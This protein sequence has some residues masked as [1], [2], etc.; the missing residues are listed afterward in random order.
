[1]TIHDSIHERQA[2]VDAIVAKYARSRERKPSMP[3]TEERVNVPMAFWDELK[4]LEDGPL[5]DAMASQASD[6]YAEGEELGDQYVFFVGRLSLSAVRI[7]L[8]E[9]LDSRDPGAFR[10]AIVNRP[11]EVYGD[12]KV[13]QI[14]RN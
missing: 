3:A 9:L 8:Q 4:W 10:A 2:I 1:M 12:G 6:A 14:C 13:V 5:A 11:S 7:A